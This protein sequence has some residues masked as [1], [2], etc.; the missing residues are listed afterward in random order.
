MID[1]EPGTCESEYANSGSEKVK[2][3]QIGYKRELPL[4]IQ[5]EDIFQSN[6][7]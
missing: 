7:C 1:G 2:K 4:R 3:G 5:K 6:N